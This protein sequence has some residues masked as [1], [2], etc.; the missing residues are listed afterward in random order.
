[1]LADKKYNSILKAL[2][3][4]RKE[5]AILNK[6]ISGIKIDTSLKDALIK[7]GEGKDE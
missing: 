4:I 7:L 6:D 1:M 3:A 2:K 5:F